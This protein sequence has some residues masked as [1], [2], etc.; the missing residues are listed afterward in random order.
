M[1]GASGTVTGQYNDAHED[2]YGDVDIT[3]RKGPYGTMPRHHVQ[4]HPLIENYVECS[5]HTVK[6]ITCCSKTHHTG[7]MI[8]T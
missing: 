5:K 4:P 8:Y 6:M 3:G 2:P 1:L 7:E